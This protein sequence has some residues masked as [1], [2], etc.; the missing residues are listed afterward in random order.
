MD[1]CRPYEKD[2]DFVE[3]Q[4][5]LA[6]PNDDAEMKSRKRGSSDVYLT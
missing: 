5:T 3:E 2:N 6:R 4:G 1:R